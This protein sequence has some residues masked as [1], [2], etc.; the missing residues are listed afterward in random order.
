MIE[1]ESN[2]RSA[3]ALAAVADGIPAADASRKVWPDKTGTCWYLDL[4]RG[5]AAGGDD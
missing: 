4:R 1:P 3:A 2:W 5:D